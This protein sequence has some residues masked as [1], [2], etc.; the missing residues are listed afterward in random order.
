[1]VFDPATDTLQHVGQGSGP[2]LA[3]NQSALNF[4]PRLGL[5][6]D[7]FRYSKTV[8]RGAY[9]IMT[10]QPTLGLVT[11]LAANPPYAFR[12]PMCPVPLLPS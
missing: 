3:Y 9:A 6:W 12:F 5:A 1:V 10:D 2:G 11:G 4:E 7:P 8:I